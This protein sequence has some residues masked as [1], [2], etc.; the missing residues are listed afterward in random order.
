MHEELKHSRGQSSVLYV[1][2]DEKSVLQCVCVCEV[3]YTLY[4]R[5]DF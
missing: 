1:F 5:K 3:K 4:H 2:V